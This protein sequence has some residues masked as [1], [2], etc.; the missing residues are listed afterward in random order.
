MHAEQMALRNHL[1]W[2]AVRLNK[3]CSFSVQEVLEGITFSFQKG[4]QLNFAEGEY[5]RSIL[6]ARVPIFLLQL[7][8]C[9]FSPSHKFFCSGT[10]YPRL[11]LRIQQE[12]RIPP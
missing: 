2:T 10:S 9:L 8:S 11:S 4:Q 5:Y 12:G 6:L 3:P 7:F 1:V